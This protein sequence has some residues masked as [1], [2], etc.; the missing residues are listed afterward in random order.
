L[1]AFGLDVF[2]QYGAGGFAEQTLLGRQRLH[3]P[4]D[5]GLGFGNV[6]HLA[7]PL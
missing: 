1:V 7:Q 3:A 6:C 2:S 4:E 5:K